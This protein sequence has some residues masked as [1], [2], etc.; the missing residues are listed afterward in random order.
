MR[1]STILKLHSIFILTET[2]FL[3]EIRGAQVQPLGHGFGKID[4]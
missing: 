3:E 2:D 4:C 1:A